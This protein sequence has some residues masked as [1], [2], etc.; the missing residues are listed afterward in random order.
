MVGEFMKRRTKRMKDGDR[1]IET[2]TITE[3]KTSKTNGNKEN[4]QGTIVVVG[5]IK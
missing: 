2:E 5:K 3:K 4:N 1:G